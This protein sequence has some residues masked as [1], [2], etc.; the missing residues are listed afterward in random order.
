MH[1]Y[2]RDDVLHAYAPRH[3]ELPL[4][5][6]CAHVHDDAHALLHLRGD[7]HAI[8]LF[9]MVMFMLTAFIM[10]M[11]MCMNISFFRTVDFHFHVNTADSL[12]TL[13]LWNYAY[14]FTNLIHFFQKK[15]LFALLSA[16]CIM[17]PSAYRRLHRSYTPDIILFFILL[18]HSSAFCWRH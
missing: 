1:G 18:L 8:H 4:P 5:Y 11:L 7:A 2:D 9:L 6:G 13:F 10:M 15:R 16:N 17:H 14:I 12:L 3:A